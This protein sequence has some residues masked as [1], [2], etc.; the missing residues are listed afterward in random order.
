VSGSS[1][2][3]SLTTSDNN[4]SLSGP[5]GAV[6]INLANPPTYGAAS[7]KYQ[8][9]PS[10]IG[11]TVGAEYA[12]KVSSVVNGIADLVFEAG[13][14]GGITAV[15]GTANQ[16][17]STSSGGGVTVSLANQIILDGSSASIQVS[18]SV[19]STQTDITASS[20]QVRDTATNVGAS[21]SGTNGV[22]VYTQSGSTYKLPVTDPVINQV[23]TAGA[24]GVCS[25]QSP[26]ATTAITGTANCIMPI[27]TASNPGI[28]CTFNVLST[29]KHITIDFNALNSVQY[30]GS[31]AAYSFQTNPVP[32]PAGCASSL[33]NEYQTLGQVYWYKYTEVPSTF[34]QASTAWIILQDM[35]Q[36]N[37]IIWINLHQTDLSNMNTI[38]NTQ[39]FTVNGTNAGNMPQLSPQQTFSYI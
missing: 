26:G 28:D 20:V 16:I 35:G 15:V 17:V 8:L 14:A 34:V 11:P 18:E 31:S 7:Q 9:P 2:V 29:L 27:G 12:L 36:A 1:G 39:L 37:F 22:T 3:T 6:S 19:G 33:A 4:V 32:Y 38:G 23:L 5:T 10:L 30:L 13:T 25:W 24:S 21:L